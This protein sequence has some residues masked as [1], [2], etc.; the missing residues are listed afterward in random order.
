MECDECEG[1]SPEVLVSIVQILGGV[2]LVGVAGTLL[3]TLPVALVYASLAD[4]SRL[5]L[6]LHLVFRCAL[7]L[8]A[9]I[10]V[11]CGCTIAANTS[12]GR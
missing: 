4:A 1:D 8:G 3:W 10:V 2:L 7:Y 9:V 6:I 12:I 5:W 11:V